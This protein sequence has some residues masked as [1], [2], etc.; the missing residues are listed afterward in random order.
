MPAVPFA[1][2]QSRRAAP[3]AGRE[4]IDGP[5]PA[6]GT[7]KMH[8]AGA[9]GRPTSPPRPRGYVLRGFSGGEPLIPILR[10]ASAAPEPPLVSQIIRK[11][12]ATGSTPANID[13]PSGVPLGGHG[14]EDGSLMA[15]S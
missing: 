12:P 13:E 11:S 3:A 6:V 5:A 4:A 9:G 15:E 7:C 1:R 2:G 14:S 8:V 10:P